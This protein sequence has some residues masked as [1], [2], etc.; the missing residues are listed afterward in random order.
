MSGDVKLGFLSSIHT[1]PTYCL[2][3]RKQITDFMRL[4]I[5]YKRVVTSVKEVGIIEPIVVAPLKGQKDK[6][7]VLD[8]HVRLEVIQA[9]GLPTVECLISTD[10]EGLTY[11][12]RVNR[13]ATIQEHFMIVRALRGG[14]SRE[15]LA[16]ALNV[17]LQ[18]IEE[19]RTLLDGICPEV[20]DMLKDRIVNAAVFKVL[21]KMKATRQQ[22]V[23]ELMVSVN[24]LT[25]SYAE[26]LLAGSKAADLKSGKKAK[27]G[28]LTAEQVA[29]MERETD[30][31]QVD[32][33][34]VET[35]YGD[36]VL[37]LMIGC[38]Y[39]AKLLRNAAV[40]R[41][42]V[43]RDEGMVDQLRQIIAATSP[44]REWSDAPPV[45]TEGAE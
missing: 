2:L 9:L 36:D 7:M 21:R 40:E 26:A 4:S 45:P 25:K 43:K 17:N 20:V 29:K 5:K 22:A 15:K 6:Y 44:D 35:R 13:L 19:R 39:V 27:Q 10:D 18:H 8:G 16:A 41:Y 14:A 11:N 37:N 24:N 12:K 33:R 31:L 34:A 32:F 23:V 38:G 30:T 3:P 42:L 1:I 28:G